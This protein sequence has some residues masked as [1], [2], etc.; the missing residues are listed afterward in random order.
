M[1]HRNQKSTTD[2][3]QRVQKRVP[4]LNLYIS[5][6]DDAISYCNEMADNVFYMRI[7]K[8]KYK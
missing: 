6:M 2:C 1:T 7:M 8:I 4:W 5:Y 3:T